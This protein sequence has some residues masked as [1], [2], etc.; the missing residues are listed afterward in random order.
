MP[1]CP[2][3]NQSFARSQAPVPSEYCGARMQ[4]MILK[5]GGICIQAIH[6]ATRLYTDL[7]FLAS[8]LHILRTEY[9]NPS[10]E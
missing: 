2:A 1:E 8:L 9:V 6:I 7:I 5:A 4:G 3:V 10:I